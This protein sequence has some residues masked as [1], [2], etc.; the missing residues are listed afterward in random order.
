MALM[1]CFLR[2]GFQGWAIDE[3]EGGLIL[4]GGIQIW[5]PGN[6]TLNLIT[7]TQTIIVW[8]IFIAILLA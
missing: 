7:L 1:K 8:T 3:A 4:G 5:L 6:V 2:A